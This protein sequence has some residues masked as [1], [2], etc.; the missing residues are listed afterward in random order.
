MRMRSRSRSFFLVP[1]RL[2]L[3]LLPQHL[4][5]TASSLLAQPLFLPLV[6][7]NRTSLDIP[8]V[9][10]AA[11]RCSSRLIA[12]FFPLFFS[13]SPHL[14]RPIPFSLY[15]YFRPA[16]EREG[17]SGQR[18]ILRKINEPRVASPRVAAATRLPFRVFLTIDSHRVP[19]LNFLPTLSGRNAARRGNATLEPRASLLTIFA[20]ASLPLET[21]TLAKYSLNIEINNASHSNYSKSDRVQFS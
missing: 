21:R 5:S 19:R 15:L 18:E 12:L 14:P 20:L 2:S 4:S 7:S 6:P 3:F 9:G 8:T 11:S 10:R 17:A 1:P 16:R 13:L